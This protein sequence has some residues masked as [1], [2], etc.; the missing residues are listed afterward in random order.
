M[1]LKVPALSIVVL[2]LLAACGR[3]G[4]FIAKAS[5]TPAPFTP[6]PFDEAS[7]TPELSPT[8][9]PTATPEG[10]ERPTQAP[11]GPIAACR[12]LPRNAAPSSL[13]ISAE[14]RSPQAR[15]GDTVQA[16]VVLDNRGDK[17]VVYGDMLQ[18]RGVAQGDGLIGG[19][20]DEDKRPASTGKQ[21][22]L[23]P[24]E[25]AQFPIVEFDT[26]QCKASNGDRPVLPPGN[27]E[28]A[29]YFALFEAEGEKV[30][31]WG[32]VRAALEIRD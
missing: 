6:F 25:Q 4:S 10:T 17:R 7:P 24:G 12:K 16:L 27:Y 32:V 21:T 14:L 8:P 30:E 19:F 31:G 3:E 20:D 23:R 11:A 13:K 2:L 1:R 15:Q 5:P 18:D 9:T 29:T 22:V 28:F 26:R